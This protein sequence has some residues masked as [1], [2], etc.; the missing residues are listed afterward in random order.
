MDASPAESKRGFWKTYADGKEG[1]L[2]LGS[3]PAV[4]LTAAR[5]ATDAAELQKGRGR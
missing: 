3:S 4:T 2:A 5:K 1:R